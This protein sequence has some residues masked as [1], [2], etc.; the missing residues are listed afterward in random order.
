M[1]I[2]SKDNE[3]IKKIKKLKDKKYIDQENCYIIEGIKLIKE[4]IQE[5]ANIKLIVVCDDC[6]QETDLESDIKY[7]IAKYEC[8]YV[9]EKIFLSLTNVVNPQGILAIVEKGK[10][11]N[12]IDYNENLF[13]VLDDIQDPGNMGTI[14]RT[15]DSLNFKQI[16]VSKDCADIYNP[17]VVRS[18]M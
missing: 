10:N 9:S 12:D 17:K 11:A 5:K 3:T 15:A 6:K 1:V 4:A 14:L 18:T 8:I 7:E 13:L 2:T 16:I